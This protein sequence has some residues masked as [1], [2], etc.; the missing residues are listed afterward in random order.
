[1]LPFAG[2]GSAD[3][4]EPVQQIVHKFEVYDGAV[5]RNLTSLSGKNYL[6]SISLSLAGAGLDSDP[7]AGTWSVTLDNENGI[8]HPQHPT[9]P[10]SGLIRAGRE[11]RIS[12]GGVFGGVPVY[13]QRM[14]GFMD[15]PS[16]NHGQRTV[17]VSGMDYI[18]LLT[19]KPL[20]GLEH[21]AES[22]SGS[23]SYAVDDVINGPT[24]W[25]GRAVFDSVATGGAGA[26]LYD[27]ADSCEIGAGEADD[28][29]TWVNGGSGIVSSEGPAQESNWF[30]RLVRETPW[31]GGAEEYMEDTAVCAVTAGQRY[32]VDFWGRVGYASGTSGG[33]ALLRARQGGVT[34]GQSVVNYNGGDWTQY[35]FTFTATATGN[36]ALRYSS[37]GK[38]AQI[39]DMIDLD[40]ISVKTYDPDTWMRYQ[41]PPGS[42]GPYLVV[43]DGQIIGQGD[44]D[45][46]IGWH[47]DLGTDAIYFAETMTIPNGT[48][49]LF[50]Y[51]YTTQT[52]D[53]VV[54]DLLV[55]AGMYADRA[56]A[57]ADMDYSPTGV[58]IDRVWFDPD[59]S[60]L[61]A[62][63]KI[64]E[65]VDYRFHF[66]Y[67][68]KPVFRPAP[69]T[70]TIDFAFT[71]PGHIR[72]VAESQERGLIRN[73]IV[74]E[75]CQRSWYQVTRD[76]KANDKFK[77]ETSDPTSIAANKEKSKTITNHLF[78]DDTSIATMLATNLSRYKDPKWY[79]DL[80]VFANPVPFELGDIISWE[81]E[82]EPTTRA[83]EDSGAVRVSLAGI[84]RDIKINDSD[85]QYKCE[86]ITPSSGSETPSASA[87]ASA[88]HS[89]TPS[90]SPSGSLTMN[91][92]YIDAAPTDEDWDVPAGCSLVEFEL[93]GTG[94]DGGP[95]G[96]L[97]GGGGG[98]GGAYA[99]KNAFATS[100]G[101]TFHIHL[102]NPGDDTEVWDG[103]SCIARAKCGG[104]ATDEMGATGGQAASCIGDVKYSGGN[105]GLTS[106]VKGNGGGSSAASTQNG[107][108]TPANHQAGANAPGDGGDGG[109]GG[110]DD[111]VGDGGISPGGGGGGAGRDNGSVP[112]PGAGMNGRIILRYWT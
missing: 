12:V 43:L 48:R 38:Y 100:P 60:V 109:N 111:S 19:D 50:V 108:S 68:G 54:A 95:G 3:F 92:I 41:L 79:D 81:L 42:N 15:E 18:S 28:V 65:R 8:F 57:L 49:N 17:D 36:L 80:A 83:N 31:G 86:I 67:D 85:F 63:T 20:G 75:G 55:Y 7:I 69:T 52:I 53:N 25:G 47:Y 88:S 24:H 98:G 112:Q 82:L 72:D 23:G 16:F 21:I 66:D 45:S 93:W 59:D 6:K 5:W 97:M 71:E 102:P 76:D 99:K 106:T 78:Q 34:I 105:G 27:E 96:A 11:V 40:Q 32:I 35:S 10:W 2:V 77:G 44:Q 74:I 4:L 62:I 64:C 58:A 9:S 22:G 61:D 39:G 26:E 33:Y 104:S 56:A 30:L 89:E 90:A 73:R 29:G 46:E 13:W 37:V 94:G 1:M 103:A 70:G 84:I 14:V 110:E 87:S 101:H 107:T 51:Y 91:E